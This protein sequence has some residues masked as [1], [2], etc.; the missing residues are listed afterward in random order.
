MHNL[1]IQIFKLPSDTQSIFMCE[2]RW[3]GE[4]R[5]WELRQCMQSN[6]KKLCRNFS[7][8]SVSWQC[9]SSC[10][11]CK[12]KLITVMENLLQQMLFKTLL[13]NVKSEPSHEYIFRRT[14]ITRIQTATLSELEISIRKFNSNV[15]TSWKA[16]RWPNICTRFMMAVWLQRVSFCWSFH[17]ISF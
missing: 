5:N 4:R 2:M 14:N 11:G 9:S 16:S 10:Q 3:G 13:C 1:W 7:F 17:C 6:M 15:I 8:Y 12:R